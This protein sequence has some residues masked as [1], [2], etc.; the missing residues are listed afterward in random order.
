[1][2]K[3]IA[4]IVALSVAVA[5]PTVALATPAGSSTHCIIQEHRVTAV[6]PLYVPVQ[7]GRFSGERLAG[8]QVFV[9]AEPG[10]TAE[11]LQLSMQRHM[12]EM[13]GS[14][15]SNCALDAKDVSVSVQSAGTGFALKITGKDGAQAKEIL[16]RAKLLVG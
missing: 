11:W 10:L 16:R 7:Q 12:T 8:A 2:F 15:M 4:A 13:R 5:L 9:L 1:M 3:K 6:Q 14:G